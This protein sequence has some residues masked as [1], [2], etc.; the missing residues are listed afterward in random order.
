LKNQ[1]DSKIFSESNVN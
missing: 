1:Y